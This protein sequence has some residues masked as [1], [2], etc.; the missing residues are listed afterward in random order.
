MPRRFAFALLALLP[1]AT[2]SA[3]DPAGV[4]ADGAADRAIAPGAA[5][6]GAAGPAAAPPPHYALS[7]R[8]LPDE[9]RIEV[10]GTIRIPAAA[11]PREQSACRSASA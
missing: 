9:R 8:V 2:G 3:V 5:A 7:V 1:L 10:S 11:G 4:A 6:P